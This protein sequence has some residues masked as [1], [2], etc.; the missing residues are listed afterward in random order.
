MSGILTWLPVAVLQEQK[1]LIGIILMVPVY[2]FASVII[3]T[4]SDCTR[5]RVVIL[6]HF[7]YSH[8]HRLKCSF[9]ELVISV[10]SIYESILIQ[11]PSAQVSVCIIVF[12]FNL[13]LLHNYGRMLRSVCFILLWAV[14]HCLLR[15]VKPPTLV[16]VRI[17]FSYVYLWRIVAFLARY[18]I[19]LQSDLINS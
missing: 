14:S 13:D 12:S 7:N 6:M 18:S 11:Y 3:L 5:S 2:T 1:W 19:Q 10:R 17:H 9:G 15:C 8:N 4:S 16:F